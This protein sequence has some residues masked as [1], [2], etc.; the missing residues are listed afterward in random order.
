MQ[1]FISLDQQIT[2]FIINIFPHNPFFDG[3]F[4][5]FSLIGASIW[6]WLI[7]I[8]IIIFFEEKKDKFFFLYFLI[9]FLAT[10]LLVNY[11]LKSYF[12]RQRPYLKYNLEQSSCPK[13]SSFPSGHSAVAFAS[14]YLLAVFDKKRGIYYYVFAI[15]VALSRIYLNCHFFFDTVG[16]GI[17][18]MIISFLILKLVVLPNQSKK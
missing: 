6:I 7:I 3:F 18:G 16:G 14:A 1:L 9:S 8:A 4:S 10:S 13:S 15:L 12:P 5:F 2:K 17:I 11:A